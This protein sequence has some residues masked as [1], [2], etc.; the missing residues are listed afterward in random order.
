MIFPSVMVVLVG[1][2]GIFTCGRPPVIIAFMIAASCLAVVLISFGGMVLGRHSL[3]QEWHCSLNLALSDP[4]LNATVIQDKN[5]AD[6]ALALGARTSWS[7]QE[8]SVMLEA[9]Q[10]TVGIAL[11]ILAVVII[12]AVLPISVWNLKLARARADAKLKSLANF[13]LP[14]PSDESELPQKSPPKL[15]MVTVNNDGA[16]MSM[17]RHLSPFPAVHNEHH[18]PPTA[19]T[20]TPPTEDSVTLLSNKNSSVSKSEDDWTPVHEDGKPIVNE[21][22]GHPTA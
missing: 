21:H 16:D 9:N 22:R 8:L 19:P 20:M 15:E 11:I 5:M 14:I 13:K 18:Q 4:G 7:A 10:T 12:A 2:L 1:I 3:P 17:S 6:I